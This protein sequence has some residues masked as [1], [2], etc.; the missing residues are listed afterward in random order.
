MDPDNSMCNIHKYSQGNSQYCLITTLIN[1]TDILMNNNAT[2]VSHVSITALSPSER[3]QPHNFSIS[4]TTEVDAFN[5]TFHHLC[6]TDKK[7][8]V[9]IIVFDKCNQQSSSEMINCTFWELEGKKRQISALQ[10]VLM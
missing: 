9:N 1:V 3:E 10:L 2:E 5:A 4:P 7:L 6:P 8:G